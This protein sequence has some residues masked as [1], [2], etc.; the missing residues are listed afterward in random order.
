M[1]EKKYLALYC[2]DFTQ[3]G[4]TYNGVELANRLEEK[5]Y[6]VCLFVPQTVFS[7]E[8]EGPLS[9]VK[10]SVEILPLSKAAQHLAK[11]TACCVFN[12]AGEDGQEERELL[13]IPGQH[14]VGWYWGQDAS[15]AERLTETYEAVLCSKSAVS[16]RV[17]N[18]RVQYAQPVVSTVQAQNW[19]Q[20]AQELC[21][22]LGNKTYYIE[23]MAKDFSVVHATGMFEVNPEQVKFL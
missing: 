17:Q 14:F 13:E 5:G 2:G 23:N 22:T 6:H 12:Y 19:E 10:D 3:Y 11:K 8:K 15:E 7:T 4:L 1:S 18:E 16:S 20:Q 21:S 9:Y